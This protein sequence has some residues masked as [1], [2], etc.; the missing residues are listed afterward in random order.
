MNARFNFLSFVSLGKL[1]KSPVTEFSFQDDTITF[2]VIV[3]I[4]WMTKC[5]GL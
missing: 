4:E 3:S 2:Q 1:Y 5:G